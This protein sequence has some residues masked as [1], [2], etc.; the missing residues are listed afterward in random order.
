MVFMVLL[1]VAVLVLRWRSNGRTDGSVAIVLVVVVIAAAV[2]VLAPGNA[3]RGGQF[4]HKHEVLRTMG[5]GA[6]QTARFLA[7]WILS[8]ALLIVSVLFLSISGWLH[9]RS[10]LLAR[11]F[12]LRPWTVIGLLVVPV[13]LAMALPYWCTG[14]L[15]QYRTGNRP[16]LLYPS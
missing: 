7:T 14:L 1:H 5:W 4:P 8:P 15:G 6:V 10:P 11:A 16:C 9:E 3:G 2:M 12:G 13:F